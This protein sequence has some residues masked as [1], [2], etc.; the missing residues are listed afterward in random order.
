MGALVRTILEYICTTFEETV[1]VVRLDLI[2]RYV[3]PCICHNANDAVFG[4]ALLLSAYLLP[5][6]KE[7]IVQ[8]GHSLSRLS[9]HLDHLHQLMASSFMEGI[10]NVTTIVDR[11]TIQDEIERITIQCTNGG[12][13]KRLDVAKEHAL[14]DAF[15]TD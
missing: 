11:G 10:A 2:Y 8:W 9:R 4:E 12:T 14:I 6:V 13:E 7:C 1:L 3:I 5:V 15:C